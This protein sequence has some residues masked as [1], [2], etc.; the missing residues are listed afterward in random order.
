[1]HCICLCVDGATPRISPFIAGVLSGLGQYRAALRPRERLHCAKARTKEGG[2]QAN[3]PGGK[4]GAVGDGEGGCEDA[5]GDARKEGE[6][7]EEC[8][9]N[10]GDCQE[11]G[12]DLAGGRRREFP[13]GE[14]D[15]DDRAGETP[16]APEDK[17][18]PGER[19]AD[20]GLLDE[21]VVHRMD[22]LEDDQD[23]QE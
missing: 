13:E 17:G 15:D 14:C 22:R 3:K 11:G 9:L 21:V 7:G 20:V 8:K 1:M 10:Q 2:S 19:A 16:E 5:P 12:W 4:E 6:A 18:G 23:L